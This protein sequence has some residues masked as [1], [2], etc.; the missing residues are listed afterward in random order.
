[1]IGELG[2]ALMPTAA[3]KLHPST[4]RAQPRA[5]FAL[6]D[7]NIQT[8][9]HFTNWFNTNGTAIREV[10]PAAHTTLLSK[11]KLKTHHH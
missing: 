10:F 3:S 1:M 2:Q 7:T 11:E 8:C 6:Q 4:H 5:L 9:S